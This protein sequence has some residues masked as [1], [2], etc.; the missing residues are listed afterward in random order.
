MWF[1]H[2]DTT[3]LTPAAVRDA[4]ASGAA[5]ISGGLTMTVLG[6]NG[7]RPGQTVSAPPEGATFT[8]TVQAPSWIAADT[9]ETIVNGE[10]V[11]VEPLLPLGAGPS[12]RFVNQVQIK[13][14][15]ERPRTWVVFHA[16][17]ESD[18]A[19]LHPGRRPF[20]ASNP[21]FLQ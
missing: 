10:T 1:G 8:V 11:S 5:N 12:K 6:P 3:A 20:A 21:M 14:D 15:P 9:L 19:P 18:L 16:K 17:G 7:E 2:D 13:V 4:L